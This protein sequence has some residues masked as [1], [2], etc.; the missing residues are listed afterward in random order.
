MSR[1]T[2]FS[3]SLLLLFVLLQTPQAWSQLLSQPTIRVLAHE[4]TFDIDPVTHTAEVTGDIILEDE[5]SEGVSDVLDLS[6]Q[7]EYDGSYVVNNSAQLAYDTYSWFGH[8]NHVQS[9]YQPLPSN[10]G[11]GLHVSYTRTG[12]VAVS[13]KGRIATFSFIIIDDLLER[14][15]ELFLQFPVRIT[16][17]TAVS[18]TGQHIPLQGLTTNVWLRR[19]VA[20]NLAQPLAQQLRVFPNPAQ[21]RIAVQLPSAEIQQIRLFDV[22]GQLQLEQQQL[23]DGFL[24][25]PA[26]LDNGWYF[27]EVQTSKGRATKKIQIQR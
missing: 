13:G 27:L 18:S 7:I 24:D 19:P 8:S 9:S 14:D 1:N 26:E 15:G 16:N 11:N 23:P 25:L 3:F 12:N 6:F 20:T 10:N 17:I 22:L 21:N 2:Y 4:D 5:M